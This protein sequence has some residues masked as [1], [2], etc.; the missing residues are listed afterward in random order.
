MTRTKKEQIVDHVLDVLFAENIRYS[1]RVVEN[2]VEAID[3]IVNIDGAS[4]QQEYL[5]KLVVDLKLEM[6]EK[7][8]SRD[9]LIELLRRQDAV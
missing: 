6:Y 1:R 7:L 9:D 2:V 3:Q 8:Q 5:E 4:V